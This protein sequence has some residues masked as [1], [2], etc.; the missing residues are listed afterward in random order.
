MLECVDLDLA[1][2]IGRGSTHRTQR[3]DHRSRRGHMVVLDQC[4][5]P[6]A[7][8]VIGTATDAYRVLLQRPQAGQSLAGVSDLCLRSLHGGHPGG[9]GGGDS[10]KVAE[11]VEQG[12]L[13]GQQSP[14]GALDAQQRLALLDV[15]PVRHPLE[16]PVAVGSEDL[17]EHHQR[18]VHPG[19]YTGFAGHQSRLGAG[20]SGHRRDRGD[21]GSVAQVLVEAAADRHERLGALVWCQGHQRAHVIAR[22]GRPVPQWRRHR[23]RCRARVPERPAPGQCRGSRRGGGSRGSRCGPVRP[24]R[25]RVPTW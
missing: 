1:R 25:R 6:E 3:G 24:R 2:Q 13:G 19:D 11:D 9:G 15:R 10:G 7:H 18:D 12:A 14:G 5:I 16:Y 4:C 8:P 20:I 21:V 23:L 17:V 22:L